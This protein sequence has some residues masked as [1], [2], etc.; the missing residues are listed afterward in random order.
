MI[1]IKSFN[2]GYGKGV[3]LY[4]YKWCKFNSPIIY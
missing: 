4:K 3:E 1:Y 2:E